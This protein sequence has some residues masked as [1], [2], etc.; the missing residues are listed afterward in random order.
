MSLKKDHTYIE[1]YKNIAGGNSLVIADDN[2]G[3]R[4]VGTKI[5]GQPIA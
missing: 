4:L 5:A 3:Y 2:G 1:V